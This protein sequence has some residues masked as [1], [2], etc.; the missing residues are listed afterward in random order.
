MAVEWRLIRDS[1][2][3]GSEQLALEE[4]AAETARSEGIGTVRVYGWQ[5]SCLS[6]GYNQDPA[7]VDWEYC[8]AAGIDVT[9]RQTGGGGI[10]HD[11]TGDVAY[12]IVAPR[13]AVPGDLLACY[14]E[15][16]RPI[17]TALEAVGLDA[18]LAETSRDALFA[19]ACYLRDVHP[20][21]DIVV[22]GA[23]VSGN[24]QYRQRDA[25]IQHGSI[26]YDVEP[27]SSLAV[28]EDHGLTEATVRE[29][30]TSVRDHTDATR[31]DLWDALETALADW[32]GATPGTWRSQERELAISLCAEKYERASWIHDRETPPVRRG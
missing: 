9:R 16:C 21:H 5:P 24:A 26:T 28:F 32:S 25:V 1:A 17:L 11:A 3:P 23:K 8:E 15:L 18:T 30:V 29:R 19:P 27:A 31:E 7:T 12:T 4:A 2:R 14:R 22:D 10:L 13:E 6:L 20:A